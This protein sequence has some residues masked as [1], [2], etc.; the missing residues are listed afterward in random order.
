MNKRINLLGDKLALCAYLL[1][2]SILLVSCSKSTKAKILGIPN[3]ETEK[4][5]RCEREDKETNTAEDFTALGERTSELEDKVSNATAQQVEV[6]ARFA[7]NLDALRERTVEL[8]DKVSNATAHQAEINADFCERLGNVEKYVFTDTV[9][10]KIDKLVNFI[11]ECRVKQDEL[12]EKVT[13]VAIFAAEC[14]FKVDQIHTKQLEIIDFVSEGH[15]RQANM[16]DSLINLINS[17]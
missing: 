3:L 4:K 8:E 15:A 14:Q 13:K 2:F 9:D 12:D 5:E 17:K 11:A 10:K 7:K 1:F 16:N 6:N